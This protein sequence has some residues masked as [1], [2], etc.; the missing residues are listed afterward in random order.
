METEQDYSNRTYKVLRPRAGVDMNWHVTDDGDTMVA[1][2]YGFNHDI[3]TG[4]GFARRIVACVNACKGLSNER[5]KAMPVAEL[6]AQRDELLSALKGVLSVA[7][8][9]IDDPRIKEFDA[10][11]AAIAKAEGVKPCPQCNT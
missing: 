3:P 11:R 7:G 10:A 2:C 9:R 4:E 6:V 8:V 5:L 1:H